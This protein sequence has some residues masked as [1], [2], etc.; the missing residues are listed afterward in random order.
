MQVY[1]NEDWTEHYL[2]QNDPKY[3][4]YYFIRSQ[5]YT[6]GLMWY[7]VIYAGHIRYALGKNMIPVV[8]MKNYPSA[9]QEPEDLGKVNVWENYF[10]QP[11]GISID[12]VMETAEAGKCSIMLSKSDPVAYHGQ[13][14]ALLYEQS[15]DIHNWR[16]LRYFGLL[17]VKNDVLTHI[18][19]VRRSIIKDGD[20]VLGVMLRGTDYI[21][22][23]AF[24]HPI[25][26]PIEYAINTVM[27]KARE[28]GCNKI[29]LATEG[30][31]YVS[32]FKQ[33]F[34]ENVVTVPKAYADY[35]L[36]D[37][38]SYSSYINDR[39]N[40]CY[41][42]GLEYLTEMIILSQC[43]YLI[44]GRASGASAVNIMTNGFKNKYYFFLGR[45]GVVWDA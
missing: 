21:K 13:S 11:M 43:P 4:T 18:E 19:E 45:Y 14:R 27:E 40:D 15:P 22:R 33:V 30:K 3:P 16:A 9:Y 39:E 17:K 23:R 5:N 31:E 32:V 42:K 12:E 41:L 2:I 26:P 24:E 44:S 20:M 29:F 8:D 34:G 37:G 28:W 25:Q 6:S 1:D 36:E 7:Y 10:E 38:K 35:R